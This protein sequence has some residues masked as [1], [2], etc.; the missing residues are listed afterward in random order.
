VESLNDR[1]A[2]VRIPLNYWTRNHLKS[3][4]F[5]TLAIGADCAGGLLAM[6]LIR[7][8]GKKLS[9]V[10][11]DFRADFLKRPEADVHFTCEDGSKIRKM[12][13]QAVKTKKRVNQPVRITATTPKISG[14][15]PVAV[16]DLTLS[17]KPQSN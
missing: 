9:I 7:K 16:F 14:K 12:I 8:S 15:E 5:G 6:H 17:L 13:A 2:V 3:M 10:F 11:K 4:Y 1:S